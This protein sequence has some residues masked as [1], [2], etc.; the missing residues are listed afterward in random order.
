MMAVVLAGGVGARLKPFTMNIPKPLLP[1]GDVP[2]LEV[3]IRQL[4]AA[5]VDRIVLTLAHMPYL[6]SAW[7]G[8]GQRFGLRVE[9][10]T[11][12]TPLGTAGPLRGIPDLEENFLVMNGD[13][14]TTLDYRAL[15]RTHVD[16][17]AW[18]TIALSQREVRI[19]F[20][21]IV[22]DA[23]GLLENYIEKP[24]LP[25]SVSMGINILNRRCLDFIPPG[26]RFDIPDLMLAM[27]RAGK[28]VV[29]HPTDCYWQDIGRFDDYQQASAD[30]AGN[31]ERFLPKSGASGA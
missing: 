7:I 16:R 3:V 24:T 31:P 12:E 21:V 29:C 8:D 25:Y 27:H 11:E 18:G 1:L 9:Y 5:G 4:A 14:L 26:V 20:G 13:L 30:F 22:S 10:A 23:A 2:I 19:D 15:I 28:P 17:A 6:F